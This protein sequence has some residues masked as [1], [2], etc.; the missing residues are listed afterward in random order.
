MAPRTGRCYGNFPLNSQAFRYHRFVSGCLTADLL[1]FRPIIENALKP[2]LLSSPRLRTLSVN[3]NHRGSS[4]H[5][6]EY[7]GFGLCNGETLPPL[8]ELEIINYPWGQQP[9]GINAGEGSV[10]YPVPVGDEF[11]YWAENLDWSQL[12]R[13]RLEDDSVF[14]AAQLAPHLAALEEVDLTHPSGRALRSI[15]TFFTTL[16]PRTLTSLTLATLPPDFIPLVTLHAP[17]LRALSVHH[18]PLPD[19]DLGLLRDRLPNLDTLSLACSCSPDWPLPTLA[20]LSTFPALR[21]LTAWFERGGGPGPALTMSAAGEL[22]A[23]VRGAPRL[24]RLRLHGTVLR[25]QPRAGCWSGWDD[26]MLG[27]GMATEF[28]CVVSGSGGGLWW[29]ARG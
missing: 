23:A 8:E 10:G 6:H 1:T 17:T 15:P 28:E 29:G 5:F 4:G 11:E 24:R 3:I 2:I 26:P 12:R 21:S 9:W 22:L 27:M 20:V 18:T 25:V 14:L 16:L 7:H 19:T 13:L